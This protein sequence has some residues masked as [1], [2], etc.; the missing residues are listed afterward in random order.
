M[1]MIVGYK[2]ALNANYI[3]ELKA[4]YLFTGVEPPPSLEDSSDLVEVN[5]RLRF[6]KSIVGVM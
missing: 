4:L 1:R 3:E 5:D 2:A 6:L